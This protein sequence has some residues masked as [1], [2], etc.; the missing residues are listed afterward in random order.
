M[1]MCRACARAV[2]VYVRCVFATRVHV[3]VQ[4]VCVC[5][6]PCVACAAG[7]RVRCMF[8]VRVRNASSK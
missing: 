3:R 7:M 4:N 2:R 8:A 5:G 1:C 6:A